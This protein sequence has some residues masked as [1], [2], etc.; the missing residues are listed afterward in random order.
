M[1]M[2][3]TTKCGPICPMLVP[4][5][6]VTVLLTETDAL[7]LMAMA[8]VMRPRTGWRIPMDQ[9][10]VCRTIQLNGKTLMEMDVEMTTNSP[11]MMKPD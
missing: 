6:V 8:T 1:A 4:M 3:I 10:T 2:V 5:R 11:S 9:Q 7:T